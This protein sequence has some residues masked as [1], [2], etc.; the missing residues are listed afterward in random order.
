MAGSVQSY[1]EIPVGI[2]RLDNGMLVLCERLPYLHSFSAGVWVRTGSANE[3]E[4]QAGISHFLEHLFFKGTSTHNARQLMQIIESKGGQLNAFTARDYTCVYIKTLDTEAC[5]GIGILGDILCDSQFV[6]FEK[7][8]N[9]ILE[10]I[11][12]NEDVPED[13]VH[14]LFMEDLYPGHALGRPITGTCDSVSG[15]ALDDVR[16]Y[17]RQWYRPENMI[18]SIVGNF[19]EAVVLEAVRRAFSPLTPT[20]NALA[21]YAAPRHGA[22]MRAVGRDIAQSHLCFGFPGPCGSDARRFVYD[23]LCNALGGGSTSRL[24]ERI[25][26]NEGLSYAVYSF[27]SCYCR[28]GMM[29]VYAAVAPENLGR[30]LDIAFEEVRDLRDRPMPAEELDLNREQLKGNLLIALENPSTRMTRLAKSMMYHGRIIPVAEIVAAVDAVTAD[31][32][33]QVAREIFTPEHCALVVLGPEE[34]EAVERIPL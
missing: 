27:Q 4:A 22:G 1:A 24:F 13:F 32:V 9:V 2:H 20:D 7:E 16:A 15:L 8:R 29:G 31:D 19:D 17:Y 30:T 18:L 25:R 5:T 12:S 21:G 10:E 3:P 34:A 14:D 6:D 33:Q 26:E 28:S 23:V 11:A